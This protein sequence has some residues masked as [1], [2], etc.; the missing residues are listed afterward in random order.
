MFVRVGPSD[1]EKNSLKKCYA[2]YI[3]VCVSVWNIGCRFDTCILITIKPQH[4]GSLVYY[5]GQEFALSGELSGE[6]S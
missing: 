2:N 6:R 4:T 3:I 5:V 1:V